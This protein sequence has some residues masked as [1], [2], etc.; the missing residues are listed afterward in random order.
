RVAFLDGTAPHATETKFPGA[1]DEIIDLGKNWNSKILQAMCDKIIPLAEEKK[2][3]YSTAYSYLG[4]AGKCEKITEMAFAGVYDRNKS[5]KEALSLANKITE[6]RK[7]KKK[8]RLLSAF[9]KHGKY[10]PDNIDPKADKKIGVSGGKI[11]SRLFLTDLKD[12]FDIIGTDYML[13]PSPLSPTYPEALYLIDEK[14]FL[15]CSENEDTVIESEKFCQDDLTIIHE[16]SR[17]A[18]NIN[19]FALDE[20]KRW[21][22]IASDLHFR[23]EEIY[24]TAMDFSKNDV[25]FNEIM[26]ECKEILKL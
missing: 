3:A 16:R 17:T 2:N 1:K 5:R 9:C 24:S 14:I 18:Q 15:S 22:G 25:I 8:I 13:F 6:N 19:E 12:A 26:C 21:F 11:T 23:L 4:L 7:S 10:K 20:A